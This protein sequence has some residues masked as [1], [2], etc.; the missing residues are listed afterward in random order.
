[1]VAAGATT[2][3]MAAPADQTNPAGQQASLEIT[4]VTPWLDDKGTLTVS[5]NIVAHADIKRPR[6][7]LAMSER[8]L[9][10]AVQIAGWAN[11]PDLTRATALTTSG[12]DTT[13]ALPDRLQNG[14][15]T[16]FT[17]TLKPKDAGLTTGDPLTT[18]GARG[19]AVTLSGVVQGSSGSGGAGVSQRLA[20]TPTFTTWFPSPQIDATR[21]NVI[22]PLTLTGFS[23]SGLID[24]REL[25]SAADSG[26]LSR[27]VD[28]ARAYPQAALAVDP[29]VVASVQAALDAGQGDQGQ[30]GDQVLANWWQEFQDV[31]STHTIVALP[32]AD[33]DLV[34]LERQGMSGHVQAALD[35]RSIITDVFPNAQTRW[36]W[37][38]AGTMTAQDF[39]RFQALG[40]DRV[41]VSEAQLPSATGYTV[42]AAAQVDGRFSAV[43]P[44]EA[45]GALLDNPDLNRATHVAALTAATAA[46]TSER[47]FDQRSLMMAFPRTD[48]TNQWVDDAQTLASLPW[49]EEASLDTTAAATASQRAPLVAGR[50]PPDVAANI[51]KVHDVTTNM[52]TFA[53][54]FTSR[55]DVLTEFRRVALTCT[56]VAWYNRADLAG[57]PTELGTQT[58]AMVGGLSIERGSD[59]LLVT[60]EETTI[61]VTVNN[62]TAYPVTLKVRL[63]TPSPQLKVGDSPFVQVAAGQNARVEIPVTGVA[64]SDLTTDLNM[65]A[66]DGYVVTNST[67]LRVQVRVEWENI[68]IAAIGISLTVVFVIGL[69]F[70]VRRG[71]R[72]LP[73]GQLEAAM[74]QAKN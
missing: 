45:L 38:A 53:S 74:E 18:W 12:D 36:A 40:L 26:A 31:A 9:D 59:V 10:N 42:S 30:Q 62:A 3:A 15:S 61:P 43:V 51:G 19:L 7:A 54:V 16:P 20:S 8:I 27:I 37:P 6:V 34:A 56:S 17:F 47:P 29:R 28:A 52:D 24:A 63:T 11:N 13:K 48:A 21:L 41:I 5:G 58:S 4:Q 22:L 64:N 2:S 60:G 39:E 14:T 25:D 72:T 32:W 23:S 70:S 1:M 33:A 35:A 57:C 68:G 71:R 55:Q 66:Q 69:F 49:L 50:V 67:P 46:I 65:V 73:P 44:N